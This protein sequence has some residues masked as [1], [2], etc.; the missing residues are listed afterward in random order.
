MQRVQNKIE[1][2]QVSLLAS[3]KVTTKLQT[4]VGMLVQLEWPAEK[5]ASSLEISLAVANAAIRRLMRLYQCNCTNKLKE[6]LD[7]EEQR[8]QELCERE[9]SDE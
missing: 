6:L 5:I 7:A 9:L 8:E 1:G 4:Q 3:K 2:I